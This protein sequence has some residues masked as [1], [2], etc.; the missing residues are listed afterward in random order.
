MKKLFVVIFLGS[1]SNQVPKP[2]PKIPQDTHN[3]ANA[4][5]HLQSLGCPEGESLEDGTT[6][7]EFCEST[8]MNG[9]ALNPSCVMKI[10]RCTDMESVQWQTI[11]PHKL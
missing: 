8:Q 2:D 7:R 11:C 1:C 4:C 9:H 10:Q 3:C 6:C 5:A